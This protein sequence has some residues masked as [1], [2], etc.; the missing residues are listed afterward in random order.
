M[1]LI[2]VKKR[3]KVYVQGQKAELRIKGDWHWAHYYLA[4][5]AFISNIF[6]KGYKKRFMEDF[7]TVSKV[8]KPVI[9]I[10]IN[11]KGISKQSLEHEVVHLKQMGGFFKKVAYSF[12]YLLRPKKRFFYE[13]EAYEVELGYILKEEGEIPIR[14]RIK[15]A[16]IMSSKMYYSPVSFEVAL[17]EVHKVCDK[18][19][20]ES[21]NI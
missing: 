12:N 6:I 10:P 2:T 15:Y 16:K 4:I 1:S 21:V 14:D 11:R 20:K 5:F 8:I 18:M 17:E 9:Y 13:L 3:R 7:I 19:E